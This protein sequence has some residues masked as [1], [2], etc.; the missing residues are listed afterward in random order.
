MTP[1]KTNK[2]GVE[3]F[4]VASTSATTIPTSGTLS[5]S[6]TGN[7]NLTNGQLGIISSS[8]FG[9]VAPESFMDAT[10]T[11][12]EA[13]VISLVQ[14]TQYSASVNG[15]TAQYPLWVRSYERSKP[16][17]GRNNNVLVT[18]QAFRLASHNVWVVGKP[19]TATSGGINVLDS[20]TYK[21]TIGFRSR[22]LEEN[23]ATTVQ[24]ANLSLTQT[25]PN[26]TDLSAT[27]PLPVDWIVS[28]FGYEINRNSTAFNAYNRY[29]GA[30]PVIALSVGLALS[31]PGG[32]AA[33]TA[34][35]GLTAGTNLSVFKYRGV[36]RSIL[37]TTELL[38][39]IQAAATASGFTHVFSIDT[40]DAGTATGGTGTGL[41]IVAL[42]HNTAYVDRIPQVKVSLQVGL[43]AGF[44]FTTVSNVNTVR[45]DEGQG[46][47]RV[48]DLWYQATAGQRK[49]TQR[50]T[51][52]PVVNFASP[53][54]TTQQY[55]TYVIQHGDNSSPDVHNIIYA[56]K[57]EIVLIPRYS[58]GTTPH[59]SIALLDTALNSW[60]A[61]TGNS[62]VLNLV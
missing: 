53:V 20:T 57:R 15:S 25:T 22:R 58:T 30:S 49:Y 27:Y 14:G 21:L 45:E 2:R 7:V 3:S 13:P 59:P 62:N 28:K 55:V 56:P 52:D 32:A 31:G 42:D 16:I 61:S 1:N 34:I 12:A 38:A 26:F 47:G 19:S 10:P 50:H 46:Y 43:P 41:F 24:A 9:S 33:G 8:S 37:L 48:L 39:A 23:M 36:V 54:D 5:D 35:S 11:F 40:A 60:L 44:N 29:R 18:K 4:L 51:Q 17:D 6:S